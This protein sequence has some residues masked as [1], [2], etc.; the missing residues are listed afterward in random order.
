MA[1]Q[2][3]EKRATA[4]V[5]VSTTAPVVVKDDKVSTS[6]EKP[7]EVKSELTQKLVALSQSKL[8]KSAELKAIKVEK[9]AELN[10]MSQ[11][12]VLNLPK[13][14]APGPLQPPRRPPVQVPVTNR[15]LPQV[16]SQISE[17][18]VVKKVSNNKEQTESAKS[19]TKKEEES[20]YDE[21]YD[22]EEEVQMPANN[23]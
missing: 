5:V 21:E 22:E 7:K 9:P 3:I 8:D 23:K 18:F 1:A 14:P 11:Q 16:P 13:R 2:P 6:V 15:P 17:A 12:P 20:E 19:A 4:P 10:V